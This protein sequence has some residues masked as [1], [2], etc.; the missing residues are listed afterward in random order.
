MDTTKC[1]HTRGT[2][3]E[4]LIRLESRSTSPSDHTTSRD[5]S[6][7]TGQGRICHGFCSSMESDSN[8]SDGEL[9]AGGIEMEERTLPK[10]LMSS[11][12]NPEASGAD[13]RTLPKGLMS[14]GRDP[15]GSGTDDRTLPKGLMSSGRDPEGSGT[16]DRT[17]PKGLMSSGRDP[18]GSGPDDRT[19]PKGLMSS[20]R[21][22][23]A[24][25]TDGRTLPK[26]LM[27]S[28][29]NPE[30]SG[31]DE[32]TL[33]KGLMSSE[34]E[35]EGE[36]ADQGREPAVTEVTVRSA[37]DKVEI[38]QHKHVTVNNYH[39]ADSVRFDWDGFD[40]EMAAERIKAAERQLVSTKHALKTLKKEMKK[41]TKEFLRQKAI[42]TALREQLILQMSEQREEFDRKQQEL[43]IQVD[44]LATEQEEIQRKARGANSFIFKLKGKYKR[45]L[46]RVWTRLKRSQL[47]Q[48][49]KRLY[50]KF[51][52][53]LQRISLSCGI[54]FVMDASP[55][56]A[57]ALAE[58][59]AAIQEVILEE[60]IPEDFQAEVEWEPTVP[61]SG[62][63]ELTP[64]VQT[65]DLQGEGSADTGSTSGQQITPKPL[66]IFDPMTVVPRRSFEM[67]MPAL[68]MGSASSYPAS[69]LVTR[70]RQLV[71]ADF[72]NQRVVSLPLDMPAGECQAITLHV[73]PWDLTVY[74]HGRDIIAVASDTRAIFLLK[75]DSDAIQEVGKVDTERQ[76]V[77][78]AS[79][80]DGDILVVSSVEDYLRPAV[81][82]VISREGRVLWT[83]ADNRNLPE[84]QWPRFL[85]IRNREVLVSD[86]NGLIHR[87]DVTTG[88]SHPALSHPD[89]KGP[90]QVT[91]DPSGSNVLVTSRRGNCVLVYCLSSGQ[92]RTLLTAAELAGGHYGWA[93]GVTE[94][95][96]MV[97]AWK[98]TTAKTVLL[99]YNLT[100]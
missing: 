59:Q 19:L 77:G 84:L 28:G 5:V 69:L 26:G 12:R 66:S 71:L 8:D 95:G 16:D 78:V 72:N 30:A 39:L 36:A 29:R 10:G 58:Q 49:M 82:D 14:S 97:V 90:G 20:G 34:E 40:K 1:V 61:D 52:I 11:G 46:E 64:P 50:L 88:T 21:D 7:Q 54:Q 86:R 56:T 75:V 62:D 6:T 37:V 18:E 42:D 44:K 55:E 91:A 68:W 63:A 13:E 100:P 23:E 53:K 93:L 96:E 33:P 51:K 35:E 81:V 45:V 80:G 4:D 9:E 15:E 41:C 87:V 47:V 32:R 94:D 67:E 57:D 27:S 85:H 43:Q 48:L 60:I 65:S 70:N 74:D 3:S 2:S 92:W 99:L 76:Y 83:V 25:G 22:P 38:I 79:F 17:L 98:R 73:H 89:L 24:S 31:A